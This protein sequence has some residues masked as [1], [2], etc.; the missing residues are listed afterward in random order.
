MRV[1]LEV[2]AQE[3]SILVRGRRVGVVSNPNGVTPT[4]VG[5]VD[6]L[7][8]AGA[9]ITALFGP[10]HGLS[11]AMQAGMHV[12]PMRDPRLDVPIY[13]LY[14][15]T[16][17]PTSSMLM[18]IDALV[19]DMQDAGAR[20][21]TYLYTLANCMRA[22]KEQ[23]IAMIVLDRPNPLGGIAVEGPPVQPDL[24]SFVGAYGLPIRYGMTIGEL[25]RYF[26]T[27][28]G[29][30]CDLT[31][32]P[33]DGWE[34]SWYY[35]YTRLPWILPSPNLPTVDSCFAFA[36]TCPIEGTNVSEGRGTTKPFELI[37]APFIDAERLARTLNSYQ[38]DGII[39][40]PCHF[41][42]TFSKWQGELCHGVQLHVTN[43]DLYRPVRTG[44]AL[45]LAL[46]HLWPEEF[47][48][49][50][51]GSQ[52][53]RLI[54]D[55]HVRQDIDA[56]ASL[57]DIEARWQPRLTHFRD[58]RAHLLEEYSRSISAPSSSPKA[59]TISADV[60][61]WSSLCHEVR[62]IMLAAG[63]EW[64]IVFQDLSTGSGFNL[65]DGA[66]FPGASTS[67]IPLL[68]ECLRQVHDGSLHFD[69]PITINVT[70]QENALHGSGIL[71][72]LHQPVTLTVADLLEL[73]INLSDNVASNI[74][75][76]L[77]GFANVNQA[78][79]RLGIH[80]TRL[81]HYF[82]DFVALRSPDH[83]SVVPQEMASLLRHLWKDELPLSS[84]ALSYL[85][86]C[87]GQTRLPLY[88]PETATI[89][90]KTGTLHG[91]VHDVGIIDSPQGAYLLACFSANGESN[92][93]QSQGIAA[94]SRAAWRAFH[95]IR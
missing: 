13:S 77:V 16:R 59:L 4:F 23:G 50:K 3:R 70:D 33:L 84:R 39:F 34:R 87:S 11:G 28:G 36:A 94:I 2:L 60:D 51:A 42:P 85:R 15:T 12:D 53:D 24:D 88:L 6:V 43:R 32:V 56:G 29:I 71:I 79:E 8:A 10:E 63:G 35:E 83:N 41:L 93:I 80:G 21:Y 65:N 69:T 57:D 44:V 26:N 82:R 22:A 67:K 37:G 7:M 73:A 64:G 62:E 20:F 30:S 72:H 91:I 81:T 66:T 78:L 74:L 1:G 27:T 55:I 95:N 86:R 25:A 76:D 31:V 89:Y 9:R 90:H 68:I 5:I 45:L 61:R 47:R 14:G 92:L 19:F 52:A 46:R 40:R 18:N 38:L 75:C 48:W 17:A 49:L 54:G 58:I